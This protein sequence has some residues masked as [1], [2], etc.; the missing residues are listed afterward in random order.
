MDI[1]ERLVDSGSKAKLLVK[2]LE[3]PTA[4][5][6]VSELGRMAG[7]PKA[8]VSNIVA[9]WQ[10]LGLVLSR[11]QGRNK[12]VF[13]NPKFYLLPE[14]KRIFEKTKNFQKPLLKKLKSMRSWKSPNI[15]AAIVF[16][17]RTRKDYTHS[18]D[19]DALIVLKDKDA[20]ATERIVEEF[21]EATKK[22][23]V[24]FSPLVLSKKDF[25]KRWREKDKLTLNILTEGKTLKGGK[26][27]EHL[28]A[29]R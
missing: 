14:L 28:Q 3:R 8:S 15:L 22:T 21:V 29:A 4:S 18:S 7:L 26:W 11:Q 20:K 2:L 13:L 17:S 6:S 10:G 19:L 5:F 24:R 16:G 23:G 25:Q 9:Q 27:I 12:L 1:L